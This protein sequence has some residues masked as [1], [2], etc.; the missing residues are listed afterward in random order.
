MTERKKQRAERNRTLTISEEEKSSLEK[1]IGTVDDLKNNFQDKMIINA[2]IFDCLDLIPN[3]YF[4]LIIIDP[5]YNLDKDFHG[6]KFFSMK[7]DAYENYLRSWFY[8]VC[9]KLKKNGSLYMCGD[10]SVLLQCNAL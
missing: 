3:E 8:K 7:S 9:D 5:P 1:L 10:G 4:D 6:K 2:D